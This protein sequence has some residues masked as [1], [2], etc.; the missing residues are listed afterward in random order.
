MSKAAPFVDRVFANLPGPSSDFVFKSWRHEDRPTKEGVGLLTASGVDVDAVVG[1]IMDVDHY[2]GN[3]EYVDECRAVSD[4]SVPAGAVRFYQ[5]IKMPILGAVHHELVM[6]DLG[7]RSGYRVLAWYLHDATEKLDAKRAARSDYNLGAWLVSQ[8]AL[9]YA[10]SSAPRKSDV[11]MLKFA[12]L[13][14]GADAAAPQVIRA[15]IE[16]MLRWASK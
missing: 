15:N 16:G 5:R 3:V 8:S 4:A 6:E 10:L 2:V 14:K 12:A 11:G 13:T 1:R 7:E 9:G